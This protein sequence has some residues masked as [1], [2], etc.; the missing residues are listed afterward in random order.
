MFHQKAITEILAEKN[1]SISA[2][3]FPP[4]N[5]KSPGIIFKKLEK[6]AA[7]DIEFISITKGAMGSLRGGTVPI[8]FMISERY[9][10]N[11][12]VQDRKSVV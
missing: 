6:L 12:L 1:F 9:K 8:G 2:E 7:L 3:I 10:K 4:R 11:A 5:G